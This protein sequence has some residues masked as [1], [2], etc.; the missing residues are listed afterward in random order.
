[1]LSDSQELEHTALSKEPRPRKRETG[2]FQSQ[3]ATQGVSVYRTINS[4]L[5]W[6]GEYKN[7]EVHI[8]PHRPH[9]LKYCQWH[10]SAFAR[11]SP[12][13]FSSPWELL[14]ES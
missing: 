3:R 10:L 14:Y 13:S 9:K 2:C 1:M 11:V 7:G 5:Q 4:K 12:H 6:H 8:V